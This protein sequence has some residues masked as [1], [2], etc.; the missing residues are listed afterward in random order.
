MLA[1]GQ[2]ARRDDSK[3]EGTVEDA[4]ITVL[5]PLGR[6]WTEHFTGGMTDNDFAVMVTAVAQFKVGFA[7]TRLYD[8]KVICQP[9]SFFP[10]A[11]GQGGAA[12]APAPAAAPAALPVSCTAA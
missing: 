1:T 10:A 3:T 4:L 9:V 11:A 2:E 8:I 7:P 12:P 6:P 5:V